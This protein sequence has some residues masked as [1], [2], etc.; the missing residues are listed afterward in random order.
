MEETRSGNTTT[1]VDNSLPEYDSF[2]FEIEPD[3][4]RLINVV[5]NNISDDSSNDPLLEEAGLFLE[6]SIPP[7]IENFANDSE[8]DIRFLVALL[9]DDSIPSPVNELSESD[10]DNSLVSRPPSKPPDDEFKPDSGEDI[11][12]VMNDIY[13]L[14]CLDPRDEFDDDDY[15]SFMFVI[16]SKVFSFLLSAK[17]ED[18]IFDPGI[19]V[20]S[21]W[22]LIG[23]ELSFAFMF[24]LILMKAQLRFSFPFALPKDQ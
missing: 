11:S 21:Q 13:E 12:V 19:L 4:E 14:E 24:I 20:Y 16:Y 17:S 5:K 3:Q 15:S 7:G 9:I 18:T 23:M 10:F 6:N 8:G 2:C 22:Y 1:H